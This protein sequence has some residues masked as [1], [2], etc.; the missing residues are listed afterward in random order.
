MI[1]LYPFYLLIYS[2]ILYSLFTL[3]LYSFIYLI[4]PIRN[5]KYLNSL[6]RFNIFKKWI[7]LKLLLTWWSLNIFYCLILIFINET[8]IPMI[9]FIYNNVRA[10][11]INSYFELNKFLPT[12]TIKS[13]F[14]ILF[15]ILFYLFINLVYLFIYLFIYSLR[16]FL[17]LYTLN[18][19]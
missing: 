11:T 9:K 7:D 2:F 17:P 16:L 6:A 12:L 5:S 4:I 19:L 13:F 1:I 8:L 15:I 3:T 18:H 14:E 10:L